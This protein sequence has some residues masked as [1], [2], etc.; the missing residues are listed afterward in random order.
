MRVCAPFSLSKYLHGPGRHGSGAKNEQEDG[1]G[2]QA[3]LQKIDGRSSA[4]SPHD[5]AKELKIDIA[6]PHGYQAEAGQDRG[7][8][9]GP[10]K[11]T[12]WRHESPDGRN[13]QHP[14]QPGTETGEEEIY[15][16]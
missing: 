12:D 15:R 6:R 3:V 1:P 10:N 7:H 8:A 9:T 13:A 14:D 16:A 4:S 5:L 2:D 11:S